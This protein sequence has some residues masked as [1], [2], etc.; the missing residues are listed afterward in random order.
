MGNLFCTRDDAKPLEPYK[1]PGMDPHIIQ[2][3]GDTCRTVG[4]AD[5]QPPLQPPSPFD[6]AKKR[7]G[8]AERRYA[9]SG[10]LYVSA[11]R[12]RSRIKGRNDG[13]IKQLTRG[14]DG[15][16]VDLV[17]KDPT[18]RIPTTLT[19]SEVDRL[20]YRSSG[21]PTTTTTITTTTTN[22]N[23]KTT[24]MNTETNTNTDTNTNRNAAGGS[25]GGSSSGTNS[26]SLFDSSEKS[27]LNGMETEI[28]LGR[29]VTSQ[30]QVM[31][32]TDTEVEALLRSTELS[33]QYM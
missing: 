24:K 29:P 17:V 12:R 19:D 8:S 16:R 9:E 23:T 30:R 25:S 6:L 3:H 7:S 10:S 2:Y 13:K 26:T 27:V 4:M 14:L 18:E 31:T 1:P 21:A 11:T 33:R 28:D 20:L 5:H 22:R 32:M 15:A